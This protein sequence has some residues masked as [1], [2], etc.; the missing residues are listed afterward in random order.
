M[1]GYWLGLTYNWSGRVGG[2]LLRLRPL[3]HRQEDCNSLSSFTVRNKL[4]HSF[5][6]KQKKTVLVGRLSSYFLLYGL[7]GGLLIT[8]AQLKSLTI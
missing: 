2:Y 1:D 6:L 4:L 5:D 7:N 8:E 3:R